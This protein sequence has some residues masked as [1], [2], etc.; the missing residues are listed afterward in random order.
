MNLEE[1]KPNL[2]KI[3]EQTHLKKSKGSYRLIYPIKDS[4][5]NFNWKNF[6]IGGRW[7]NFFLILFVVS[8]MLYLSWGHKADIKA[9]EEYIEKSCQRIELNN[10][11]G[12]LP[13]LSGLLEEDD[14]EYNLPIFTSNNDEILQ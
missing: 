6:L 10:N 5:G 11:Y 13:N 8:L 7:S 3:D 14:N 12:E 1:I 4:K 2:Y 9:F